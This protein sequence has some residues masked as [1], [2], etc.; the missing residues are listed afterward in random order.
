MGTVRVIL[1]RAAADRAV[2]KLR[3]RREGATGRSHRDQQPP[4]VLVE[5]AGVPIEDWN[6]LERFVKSG[7]KPGSPNLGKAIAFVAWLLDSTEEDVTEVI[8]VRLRRT[9]S[10]PPNDEVVSCLDNTQDHRVL[11][12]GE[13]PRLG[14]QHPVL[15]VQPGDRQQHW[16][17][18]DAPLVCGSAFASVIYLGN[19]RWLGHSPRAR[20]PTHYQIALYAFDQPWPH[21]DH[22]RTAF[23]NERLKELTKGRSPIWTKR[24]E[25]LPP[26]V[27]ELLLED[28]G[29]T[30]LDWEHVPR[31][32]HA[33]SPVRLSWKGSGP[34]RVEVRAT[35]E[36]VADELVAP[37]RSFGSAD[38]TPARLVIALQDG[39]SSEETD[40]ILVPEPGLYRVK[41]YAAAKSRALLDPFEI[42]LHLT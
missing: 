41:L 34:V 21:E 29:G 31:E 6:A 26:A 12:V 14:G 20:R 1:S 36:A 10:K 23:T 16:Y 27:A 24:V 38:G 19:P 37:P 17:S 13:L 32:F 4:E 11:I 42:W 2:D 28:G 39:S 15:F 25:R 22:G 35:K 40:V 33:R 18:Q 5:K 3:E 9:S 30:V 8:A 7:C